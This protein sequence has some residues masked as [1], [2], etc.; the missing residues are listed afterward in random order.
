MKVDEQ[1]QVL[2][3]CMHHIISD[4]WSIGVMVREVCAF[5][6]AAVTGKRV[7]MGELEVQYADYAQWQRDHL[8]GEV[9][10]R[11]LEYWKNQLAGASVLQLPTDRHRPPIQSYRGSTHSFV[12]PSHL[13]NSLR[14]SSLANGVTLFMTLLS[15]FKVLLHRYSGQ[16][17]IIVG[18]PVAG[19]NRME[20]ESLIGLF[21][22]TLVLRTDFSDDPTFR[23][24]LGRLR[25]A[26]LESYAHDDLPFERLV[27]ELQ[28]E[29]D[30]SRNPL[31][32]VMFL[33]QHERWQQFDMP[34]VKASLIPWHTGT[35]KFDLTLAIQD[36]GQQLRAEIEY[37]TDLYDGLTIQR[38][39]GH[40]QK[41]LAQ[42][43]EDVD[44]KVSSIDLLSDSERFE[45]IQQ[46][47]LTQ[48]DYQSE[49]LLHKAFEEQVSRTPDNV[50]VIFDRQRLTY[51]ELDE[52]ANQLAHH[53]KKS[54]VGPDVFVGIC[55]E[56][57]VE[58]VIGLL[59]I[60]K[61][62]GAYVPLDPEYPKE[63]LAFIIEDAGLDLLLTQEH[64]TDCLPVC[65]AKTLRLDADWGEMNVQPTEPCV[66]EVKP[67]NLAY[68]IYTSGSTG[69]P[70]GVMISHS[71]ICN[72]LLWMQDEYGLSE[73]DL[74]LQ[75][76]SFGFDVSVWEFFWPLMVGARLVMARPGGHKDP[77]YLVKEIMKRGITT[78]HFV[79]AMLQAFVDE[80]SSRLCE[81]LKRVICS[82]EALSY[83]LQEKFYSR[84]EAELHN[85]YGPT[86]ASVDVTYWKCEKEAT[87]RAVPIGRPI[88]NTQIYILDGGMKAVPVGVAGE[89]YI[90]GVGLG[91]GYINRPDLTGERFVPNPYERG[92]GSRLYATGDLARYLVDG[93]IEYI[94]RLDHQVKIRGFRIELGEI[95]AVLAWHPQVRECLVTAHKDVSGETR[96]VAYLV[97]EGEGFPSGSELRE[98][99]GEKLPPYMMPTAFVRL[100]EMPV[101]ANGKVDRK[102]LPPADNLSLKPEAV[103]VE[104]QNEAQRLIA[105]VMRD[106]LRVDKIGIHHN[107]FDVGAHSLLMVQAHARLREAFKKEFPLLKIFE[108]PTI[109]SLARYLTEGEFETGAFQQGRS[110]GE[111]R[112]VAGRRKP[113][114]GR[115]AVSEVAD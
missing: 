60:L 1:E 31:F 103:Y 87:R 111:L 44:R 23:Q 30:L 36:D 80:P 45:L 54:G 95:E 75:K 71:G 97:G 63:R 83:E 68:A 10:E 43:A 56:R 93:S 13:A 89:L 6:E 2:V 17:D 58:M 105:E 46:W 113:A 78:M 20:L 39:A 69:R 100:E 108:S 81:S 4:G 67:D 48:V 86:E 47:N 15:A 79:P 65:E 22:N 84:L 38:M 85:L 27:E 33:F 76:T 9:L 34:G 24:A 98:Y 3:I 50:A 51:R 104:P 59:G 37:N 57:S 42:L 66:N 7:E 107:F 82:G 62:G 106:L 92:K 110:R 96:L 90:G 114:R 29:R 94:G 73:S 21:V 52:R 91:R 55:A 102:A 72:R 28:T 26:S 115:S 53:L 64:L 16:Q 61:A 18:T 49:H 8:Q 74:V 70:K 99:V 25:E 5:Y 40:F 19:R 41:A 88:A 112:K 32:Q 101:T 77:V 11:L 12:I 35:A 14:S 109:S